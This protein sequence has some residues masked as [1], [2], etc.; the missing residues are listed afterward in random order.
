MS[1][2]S[3]AQPQKLSAKQQRFV[4]AYIGEA[5]FNASEAVRLAGYATRN[6]NDLGYQLRNT[7]HI[8]ARIDELLEAHTLRSTE[9]LRELTDVAM[10]GLHEFVE[11]TKY[12]KEGNPIAA[13]MD[14]SAK[15]KALELLGK[16]QGLFTDKQQIELDGGMRIEIVGMADEELP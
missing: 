11:V 13:R 4:D 16:S 9:V 2:D 6:A 8:R 12:D 14:A 7:P 1:T 3:P 10:R 5:R 15:M